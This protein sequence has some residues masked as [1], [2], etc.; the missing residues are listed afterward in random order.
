MPTTNN[1]VIT[2]LK[3]NWKDVVGPVLKIGLD[4][5][6]DCTFNTWLFEELIKSGQISLWYF[7]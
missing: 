2:L 4:K 3:I 7:Y 1:V 5:K 6:Y